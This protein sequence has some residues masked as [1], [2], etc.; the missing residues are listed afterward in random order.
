M[1]IYYVIYPSAF[2]LLIW[3]KL[4]TRAEVLTKKV[5]FLGDLKMPKFLSEINW[6]MI[7][8]KT[9]WSCVKVILFWFNHSFKFKSSHIL[10]FFKNNSIF[11]ESKYNDTLHWG[12][13]ILAYENLRSS[14]RRTILFVKPNYSKKPCFFIIIFTYLR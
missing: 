10:K 3:S 8:R 4:E 2:I 13:L 14:N 1:I 5:Y 7:H 9:L 12:T 11:F 6:P